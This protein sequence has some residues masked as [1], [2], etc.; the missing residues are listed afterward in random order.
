MWRFDNIH[1]Q[2]KFEYPPGEWLQDWGRIL[3]GSLTVLKGKSNEFAEKLFR[4][5]YSNPDEAD[6]K[7]HR[8]LLAYHYLDRNAES[9][10]K[11]GWIIAST[12]QAT[13]AKP[14]ALALCRFFGY[15]SD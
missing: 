1:A 12:K 3:E 6:R 5:R 8:V 13:V 2:M 14:L 10:E 11:D 4:S 15:A 7:C 9:F